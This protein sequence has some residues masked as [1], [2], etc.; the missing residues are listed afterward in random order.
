MNEGNAKISQNLGVLRV[1][2]VFDGPVTA[3]VCPSPPEKT[4]RS[5]GV[6]DRL[7]DLFNNN[8]WFVSGLTSD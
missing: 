5:D 6:R 1:L 3:N 7:L 8:E 4:R 2:S